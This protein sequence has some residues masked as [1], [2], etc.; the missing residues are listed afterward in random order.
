[1]RYY[2]LQDTCTAALRGRALASVAHSGAVG[3]RRQRPHPRAPL[4]RHPHG[5]SAVLSRAVCT[6]RANELIARWHGLLDLALTLTQ[7]STP[8]W[9][10]R[11]GGADLPKVV[12]GTQWWRPAQHNHDWHGKPLGLFRKTKG[13]LLEVA[14]TEARVTVQNVSRAREDTR[15]SEREAARPESDARKLRFPIL[16]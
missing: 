7:P 10:A 8:L 14:G 1:M 13:Q 15:G 9:M 4:T 3:P 11:G 12:N 2:K 5:W 16:S 6:L